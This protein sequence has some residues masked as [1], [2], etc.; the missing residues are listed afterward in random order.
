MS[1]TPFFFS[2]RRRHTSSLRD[3]SSDVCSSDL[4]LAV[5]RKHSSPTSTIAHGFVLRLKYHPGLKS[6][7]PTDA[8]SRRRSS[9]GA[10]ASRSEE[11]R[12]GKEGREWWLEYH[13]R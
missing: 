10:Y 2:S 11:R 4:T 5:T 1:Y 13:Q 3:W 8:T 12:V 9:S 7:P 6:V